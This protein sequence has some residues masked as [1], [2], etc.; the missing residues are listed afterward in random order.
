MV[1]YILGDSGNSRPCPLLTKQRD[2]Q[3]WLHCLGR[4]HTR[5]GEA[6]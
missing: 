5:P 6:H 1:P 4:V 2:F 3:N